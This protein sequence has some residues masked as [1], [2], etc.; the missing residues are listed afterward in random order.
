VQALAGQT[1]DVYTAYANYNLGV[2]LMNLGQCGEAIPYLEA[3]RALQPK[4]HEVERALHQARKC[5]D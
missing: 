2:T 1:G 5:T 3:S 4:R